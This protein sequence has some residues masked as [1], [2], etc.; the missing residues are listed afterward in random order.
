[1]GVS[2][3]HLSFNQ[4]YKCVYNLPK[5]VFKGPNWYIWFQ[6]HILP[7]IHPPLICISFYYNI[8]EILV[9][10][11]LHNI[12]GS[13]GTLPPRCADPTP[14]TGPNSILFACIF[15]P[16]TGNPC[17]ALHNFHCTQAGFIA[18]QNWHPFMHVYVQTQL[19]SEVPYPILR[20]YP[21]SIQSFFKYS[22]P[23]FARRRGQ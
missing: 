1:M 7:M 4:P 6:N 18:K 11:F 3:I 22:E 20:S 16:P 10:F 15:G 12:G 19:C 2:T 17:S 9:T 23:M 14:S 13:K 8:I 21:S 5:V